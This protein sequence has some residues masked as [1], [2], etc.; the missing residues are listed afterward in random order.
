MKARTTGGSSVRPPPHTPDIPD[1]LVL[2]ELTD[3]THI[4]IG[5]HFMYILLSFIHLFI[6]CMCTARVYSIIIIEFL[7]Y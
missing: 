3:V 1:W 4:I 6:H 7:Y 5:S 2:L